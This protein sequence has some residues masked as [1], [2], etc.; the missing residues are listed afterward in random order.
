MCCSLQL[1]HA[2]PQQ[3]ASSNMY[4]A[5]SRLTQGR[6]LLLWLLRLQEALFSPRG[7]L[8]LVGDVLDM[9]GQVRAASVQ[10]PKKWPSCCGGHGRTGHDLHQCLPPCQCT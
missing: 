4:H 7:S 9:L 3:D 8:S 5:R 1:Y 10:S 6:F 2:Q